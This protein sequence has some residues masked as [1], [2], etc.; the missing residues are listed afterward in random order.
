MYTMR[1]HKN[2]EKKQNEIDAQNE[3]DTNID[4]DVGALDVDSDSDIS[5]TENDN[6]YQHNPP[7]TP[8]HEQ[9]NEGLYNIHEI[10]PHTKI[11]SNDTPYNILWVAGTY[12]V[13]IS[14]FLLGSF[15]YYVDKNS[16]CECPE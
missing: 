16:L 5:N 15:I 9:T 4:E 6:D 12:A 1:H 13:C 8:Y 2:M 3:I 14:G 11:L 7:T 10:L